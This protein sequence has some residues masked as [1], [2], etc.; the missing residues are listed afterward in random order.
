MRPSQPEAKPPH[1]P[2]TVAPRPLEP[3]S[4]MAPEESSCGCCAYVVKRTGSIEVDG[5]IHRHGLMCFKRGR[6]KQRMEK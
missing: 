2:T 5:V 1:G 4:I 6:S 3:M